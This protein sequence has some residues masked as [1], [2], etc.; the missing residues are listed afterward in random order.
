MFPDLNIT[1]EL[2]EKLPAQRL[3]AREEK[4]SWNCKLCSITLYSVVTYAK[5]LMEHY[6]PLLGVFCDICNKK[7]NYTSVSFQYIFY[8]VIYIFLYL[9]S[10]SPILFQSGFGETQENCAFSEYIFIGKNE[11]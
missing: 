2:V 3:G 4:D 9:V 11:G 7:F 6:K 1:Q 5:H 8:Y 10:E